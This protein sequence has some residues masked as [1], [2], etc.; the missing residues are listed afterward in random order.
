MRLI[1]TMRYSAPREEAVFVHARALN[2]THEARG[3]PFQK[4][5]SEKVSET[6]AGARARK[7]ANEIESACKRF[8]IVG[9]PGRINDHLKRKSLNL[10]ATASEEARFQTPKAAPWQAGA[11]AADLTATALPTTPDRRRRESG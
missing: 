11:C 2:C 3:A 6:H 10:S 5:R 7:V 1:H 4:K 9:T 8:L